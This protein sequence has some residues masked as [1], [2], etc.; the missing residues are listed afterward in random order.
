[1][2]FQKVCVTSKSELEQALDLLNVLELIVALV[3]IL[4]RECKLSVLLCFCR[5]C[6]CVYVAYKSLV[7]LFNYLNSL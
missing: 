1:M 2:F 7:T 5:V 4:T 3:L 6:V